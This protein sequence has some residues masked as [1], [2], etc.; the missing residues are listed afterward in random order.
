MKK[1]LAF[2][3]CWSLSSAL[4]QE[5]YVAFT[6][7]DL[8]YVG[9]DDSAL[10]HSKKI[11]AHFSAY[12]APVLGFVND[13]FVR[14]KKELGTAILQ[15]WIKQDQ[16]LGNHTY[17]HPSFTKLSL[18][19][20][21]L[22]VKKGNEYSNA[23]QK[24]G[25]GRSMR[26]FRHPYLHT[27]NDS[28]KKYGLEKA[29][30]EMKLQAVPVTMD[31]SDWY[32]NHAY[33]KAEGDLATRIGQAYVAFTLASIEYDE[34]LALEVNGAPIKHVFLTHA[35][36]INARFLPDILGELAKKGY[37]FISTEEALK[38]PVY[39]KPDT[40][41]APGGFSWLH[42]W[43]ISAKQKTALIEPEIPKFVQET[44]EK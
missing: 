34:K 23:L 9:N 13:Q 35:N 5:K 41:I 10:V 14:S 25:S 4:A 7:D 30:K 12:K 28:V 8:P 22:D 37:T 38:D 17:S 44:Y 39:R 11:L 26:Y 33:M 19:A 18:E 36:S 43:R 27:G 32:F 20:Y 31:G 2:L 15:E 40:V 24:Q 6:M 21:L 42:R 29:L 1:Y 16:E 3:L